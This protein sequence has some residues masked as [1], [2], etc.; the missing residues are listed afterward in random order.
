MLTHWWVLESP[1]VS[2]IDPGVLRSKSRISVFNRPKNYFSWDICSFWDS[3][4][5]Q[6]HWEAS[7]GS[8]ETRG[9]PAD[10]GRGSAGPLRRHKLTLSSSSPETRI[11]YVF[12]AALEPNT[13]FFAVLRP[14]KLGCGSPLTRRVPGDSR[15]SV[16]GH[17]GGSSQ[18]Y[19]SVVPKQALCMYF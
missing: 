15:G 4:G 7:R 6:R 3:L 13:H 5:W 1:G 11:L 18:L 9:E 2:G 10:D 14:A 12:L 16:R 19:A 8:P 17:L